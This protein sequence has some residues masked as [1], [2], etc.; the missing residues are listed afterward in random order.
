[1][2]IYGDVNAP[3]YAAIW[4]GNSRHVRKWHNRGSELPSTY[5]A[6][7][8]EET[9]KPLR[10]PTYNTYDKYLVARIIY[11]DTNVGQWSTIHGSSY[12]DIMTEISK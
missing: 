4:L 1:M 12:N 11:N 9:S 3:Q 7:F 8:D 2:A 5:Q 10:H 6:V